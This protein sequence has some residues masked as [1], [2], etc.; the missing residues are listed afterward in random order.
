MDFGWNNIRTV[1]TSQREAFEELVS[2]LARNESP[3]NAT[4]FI[5]KGKP[6]AG[7]ECF[8]ILEN[9]NEI[10]WQVKFFTSSFDSTQWSQ[11]DES[12][13]TALEKHHKLEKYI[14]AFPIDPPDAR[15]EKQQSLLQKW[16]NRVGTWKNSAKKRGMNV[17]FEA[18]WSSDLIARLSK[19]ENKGLTYFFFNKDEFTDEWFI[20]QNGSAIADLAKRYTPELN[21]DLEISEI[22]SGIARDEKFEEVITKY[23]DDFLI[24]G[25]KLFSMSADA[26]ISTTEAESVFQQ[27]GQLFLKQNF[28]VLK[29]FPAIPLKT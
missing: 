4:K 27:I 12:V 22:F 25:K 11:I 9:G 23:F 2:Q 21:F 8:W 10:A 26:G 28:K 16:E 19:H 20:E 7:V 18:W 29:R 17:E 24:K 14:I 6:D 3:A 15:L 13:K 1:E 5:R